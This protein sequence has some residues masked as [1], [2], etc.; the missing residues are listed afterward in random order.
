MLDKVILIL[1]LTMWII[2]IIRKG[3]QALILLLFSMI[4]YYKSFIFSSD[5]DLIIKILVLLTL[6]I[7][8]FRFGLKSKGFKI[9][10]PFSIILY[11]F[12]FK[13]A[14]WNSNYNLIDSITAF[15]SF[16]TGILI[17]IINWNEKSKTSLLK[18]ITFL[19]IISIII[20][21][22]MDILGLV[23][24]WGRQGNA[25]AGA[26]LST[27]LSF[28]G[29]CGVMS[30]TIMTNVNKN[31]KY[32]IMSYINLAIVC[33]TLTRGGIIA[34]LIIIIPDIVKFL[35]EMIHDAKKVNILLFTLV[36]SSYPCVILV[37]KLL[38]RTFVGGEVNTSGR[39]EAWL[40]MVSESN[41]KWFGNGYGN[42][43][44]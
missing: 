33:S 26:S 17:F 31:K 1:I 16:I 6:I 20:G 2:C 15:I 27:N 34:S 12:S 30:A 39:T 9:L 24:F 28:F 35:K 43:N 14:Q 36:I 22:P 42:F 41:S 37:D 8:G 11:L 40:Y 19:P 23:D 25:L 4:I 44:R 7:Y 18:T 21:L 29:T 38:K 3:V 13:N 32:R 5:I 10:I